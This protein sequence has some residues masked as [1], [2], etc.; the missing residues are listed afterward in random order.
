[1]EAMQSSKITRPSRKSTVEAAS[2][3]QSPA[4]ESASTTRKSR[5]S[6]KPGKLSGEAASTTAAKSHRKAPAS[7]TKVPVVSSATAPASSA[8]SA[9]ATQPKYPSHEE[10]ARLAYHY[11]L[12]RG[13]RHGDAEQD[14]LRAERELSAAR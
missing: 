13:G 10:I 6:Q 5:S 7:R 4:V 2:P 12:E 14:W 9:P 1:M 11:W 8:V 3:E